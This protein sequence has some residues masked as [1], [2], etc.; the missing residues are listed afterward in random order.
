MSPAEKL[1]RGLR[2]GSLGGGA[3]VPIS[4]LRNANVTCLCRFI[5]PLPP[6]EFKKIQ[7]PM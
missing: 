2:K 6:V 3:E 7:C 4:I 1:E 5:F